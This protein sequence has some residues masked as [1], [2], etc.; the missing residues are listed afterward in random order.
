[1]SLGW[2]GEVPTS[3]WPAAEND[4]T[5]VL[6]QRWRTRRGQGQE[7]VTLPRANPGEVESVRDFSAA[8]FPPALRKDRFTKSAQLCRIALPSLASR[9]GSAPQLSGELPE[10][11]REARCTSDLEHSLSCISGLSQ[12]PSHLA[13]ARAGESI[14]QEVCG[15]CLPLL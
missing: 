2:R 8:C 14:L 4:P 15:P 12:N 10:G 9:R 3:R 1:M 11:H 6:G 13:G 5:A 7:G